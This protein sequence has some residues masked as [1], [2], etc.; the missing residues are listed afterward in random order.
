M[1]SCP[2]RN[3][4]TRPQPRATFR[5]GTSIGPRDS[6]VANARNVVTGFVRALA[7]ALLVGMMLLGYG[8]AV[9]PMLVGGPEI[10]LRTIADTRLWRTMHL[11]MLAGS[12]LF[13]AGINLLASLRKPYDASENPWGGTTLEWETQS[14]PITHN[15]EHDMVLT[16][17]PY[18]YRP[19]RKPA[20]DVERVRV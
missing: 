5:G 10:Q 16:H 7:V 18:D 13:M 15:F 3:S 9:H 6:S 11:L 4:M 20:P 17:A 19:M 1:W 2:R 8:A 12:G 14:P